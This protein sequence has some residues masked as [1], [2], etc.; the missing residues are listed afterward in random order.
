MT[1]ADQILLAERT[2]WAPKDLVQ[3]VIPRCKDTKLK[4]LVRTCRILVNGNPGP[5]KT[6]MYDWRSV[7]KYL[8]DR[9]GTLKTPSYAH[10][11]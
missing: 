4:E 5:G 9:D 10:Q 6:L 1:V 8:S 11:R 2:G 7:K 3:A